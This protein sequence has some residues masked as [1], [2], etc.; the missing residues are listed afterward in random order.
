MGATNDMGTGDA[1]A[2]IGE[3]ID[4]GLHAVHGCLDSVLAAMG[5][6]L[7][8]ARQAFLFALFVDN[9]LFLVLRCGR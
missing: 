3:A 4:D 5:N 9:A 7:T 1:L 2:A 8:L 6:L